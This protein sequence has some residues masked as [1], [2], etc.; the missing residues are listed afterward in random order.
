V[1]IAHEGRIV[2]ERYAEGFAADAPLLGWSMSKS[3]AN[4]LVGRLVGAGDLALDQA[5]LL[6]QWEDDERAEITVEELLQMRS[7]LAFEEVYEIGTDATEML[8]T[9]GSVA[10]L[11]ASEPLVAAPGTTWSY[12][13]GTTNILCEV[14]RSALGVDGPQMLTDQVFEPLGMASAVMEPDATGLPV[15]SSFTYATARDW[16]KLGQ[17]F[18]DEG[19][20]NGERFLPKD[21]VR[22]STAPVELET[23]EPYG[24][25]WWLNAGPEGGLRMP[26]VP[27]DAFWASGNEGQQ[28][29]VIPS[30]DLVVVRLG[31]SRG[32]EGIA[33][34]L[35]PLLGGALRAVA[36]P[37]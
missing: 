1:V 4:V 6:P 10:A 15:C 33:W 16:A 12:S 37:G 23:E 28:V 3:L 30:A 21:W 13:S 31:L 36:Q 22:F 2:A 34:G 19:F 25:Q 18:L 20:W 5:D 35:E 7:G 27:A 14:A 8:Y 11:P 24:A 9:P 17:L 26:S 32:Y 29:A